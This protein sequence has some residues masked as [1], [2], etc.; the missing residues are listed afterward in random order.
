MIAVKLSNVSGL[1]EKVEFLRKPASYP[2]STRSVE[3]IETHMSWVF[4]TDHYAYKLKKPVRFP[5]LD[6][7]TT[8]LRRRCCEEEVRLNRRLAPRVYIGTIPLMRDARGALMLGGSE[9]VVDWLVK[10]RRLPANR[11]LDRAI[12]SDSFTSAEIEDVAR[13]LCAFYKGADRIEIS[14]SEY[15]RRLENYVRENHRELTDCAAIAEHG[16]VERTH[17]AQLAFLHT[18]RRVFEQRVGEGRIV[19]AHGD[20]RPEH[21]QL[22]RKPQIIDRVEFNPA[23]RALDPADELAFFAMECEMLGAAFVGDIVLDRYRAESGDA[24]PR[25]LLEFYKSYRACLRAK[26]AIWHLRDPDVR[27]PERWPRRARQYLQI[28]SAYA[29]QLPAA[30]VSRSA[31]SDSPV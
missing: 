4:L 10:M 29:A 15:L 7:S 5:F 3:S 27:E 20:L 2:D 30:Y 6:F 17:A 31:T 21:V 28:A 12:R 22:G 11:M 24:P 8:E 26:L 19:D 25:F 13:L 14:A 18:H 23:F 1:D 9:T 16:A